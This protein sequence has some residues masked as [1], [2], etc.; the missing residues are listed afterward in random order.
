MMFNLITDPLLTRKVPS[1]PLNTSA[2]FQYQSP[3]GS[4]LALS[5]SFGAAPMHSFSVGASN[6][7]TPGNDTRLP[8][9]SYETESAVTELLHSFSFLI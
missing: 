3:S 4:G 9:E 7:G 5:R 6:A 2:S 1:S 8:L